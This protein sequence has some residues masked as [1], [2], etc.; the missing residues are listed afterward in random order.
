MRNKNTKNSKNCKHSKLEEIGIWDGIKEKGGLIGGPTARCKSCG[1]KFYFTWKEWEKIPKERKIRLEDAPG[2]KELR[3]KESK[4]L[5]QMIKE[6]EKELG[7]EVLKSEDLAL[8][9]EDYIKKFKK[10]IENFEK[11]INKE[12]KTAKS[13]KTRKKYLSLKQKLKK[14][15]NDHKDLFK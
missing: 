12:L 3:K 14:T 13:K 6:T 5:K 7:F 15:K 11:Y 10:F 9:Y 1:K 8:S 4:K 2:M